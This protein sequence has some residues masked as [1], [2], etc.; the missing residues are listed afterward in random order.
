MRRRL[1]GS[2]RGKD[3][4]SDTDTQ[5]KVVGQLT[6]ALT[7]TTMM[8]NSNPGTLAALYINTTKT[9]AQINQLTFTAHTPSAVTV[10]VTHKRVTLPI[11]YCVSSLEI[12]VTQSY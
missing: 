4:C 7:A 11:T 9:L 1:P 3:D 6:T 8:A 10:R 12:R 5:T 2:L